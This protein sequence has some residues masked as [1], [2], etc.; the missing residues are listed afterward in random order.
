MLDQ[1]VLVVPE[2]G[3]AEPLRVV[4]LPGSQPGAI[5]VPLERAVVG[6]IPH[7]AR[8]LEHRLIE[9]L[10]QLRGAGPVPGGGRT[11]GGEDQAEPGRDQPGGGGRCPA[12]GPEIVARRLRFPPN[13]PG[14]ESAPPGGRRG[15]AAAR[16]PSGTY[17]RRWCR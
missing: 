14:G 1:R 6:S 12:A 3:E 4:I 9:V 2:T 13:Q 5:E 10:G 11:A 7:G 8:V 15:R 16:T 17:R